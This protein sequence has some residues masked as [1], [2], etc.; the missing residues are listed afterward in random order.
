MYVCMYVCMYD[1][2]VC[3]CVC[4][5]MYVYLH[6]FIYLFIY[7]S[8]LLAVRIWIQ[9][10]QFLM[11]NME[12]QEGINEVRSIFEKAITA[13]GLH[14]TEVRASLRH[15]TMCNTA[16]YQRTALFCRLMIITHKQWQLIGAVYNTSILWSDIFKLFCKQSTTWWVIFEKHDIGAH[17]S[18]LWHKCEVEHWRA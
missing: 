5:C 14:V 15:W 1:M 7:L 13:A 12:G 9:Y 11:D 2:Y 6:F 4:V 10:C 8:L 3:V 16:G 17:V 18:G